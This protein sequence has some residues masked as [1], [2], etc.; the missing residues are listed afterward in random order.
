MVLFVRVVAFGAGWIEW[1]ADL[2]SNRC[3]RV[4]FGCWT[5]VPQL[6]ADAYDRGE[7]TKTMLD[8]GRGCGGALPPSFE[9]IPEI[10]PEIVPTLNVP[11]I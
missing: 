2:A 5:V 1:L 9:I 6:A 11:H 3:A 4:S 7:S 8:L 10:I